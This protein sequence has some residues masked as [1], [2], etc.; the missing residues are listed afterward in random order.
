MGDWAVFRDGQLARIFLCY[1]SF[2]KILLGVYLIVKIV[3]FHFDPILEFFDSRF[4][5]IY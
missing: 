3:D 2:G 5:I 4:K 1:E